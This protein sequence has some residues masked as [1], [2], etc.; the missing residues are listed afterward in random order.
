M[1]NMRL[2]WLKINNI[3]LYFEHSFRIGIDIQTKSTCFCFDDALLING[4]HL[5]I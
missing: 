4:F 2:R 1:I 3:E 5:N